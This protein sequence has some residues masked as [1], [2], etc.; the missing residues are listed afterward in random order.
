MQ[1]IDAKTGGETGRG[2]FWLCLALIMLVGALL[3]FW[4]LGALGLIVDEGYQ[5]L[6]VQ[7]ILDH[8]LPELDSGLLYTRSFIFLYLQALS[9][10]V[11][12]LNEFAM[13]FPAALFGVATIPLAYWFG[14]SL[15]GVRAG[16]LLAVL[17][18]LSAW[19]IEYARYA[20]FYT[21]FQG[22]YMIGLV[23]WFR[24]FIQMKVGWRWAFAGVF[25]L[26]IITQPLGVML[27]MS[28]VYLLPL[29]GYTAARKWVYFFLAGAC[30]AFW[31]LFNKAYWTVTDMLSTAV[32]ESEGQ[33]AVPV[34]TE[35]ASTAVGRLIEKVLAMVPAVKLPGLRFVKVVTEHDAWVLVAGAVVL[36]LVSVLIVWLSTRSRWA[37]REAGQPRPTWKWLPGVVLLVAIAWTGLVHMAAL[38]MVLAVA[39]LAFYVRS[40]KQLLRPEVVASALSCWAGM[41][42]WVVWFKLSPHAS[43]TEGLREMLSFPALWSYWFQWMLPGWPLMLG[44]M[45]VG[46]VVLARR[47]VTEDDTMNPYWFILAATLVPMVVTAQLE[48]KFSESRYFFHLYPLMLLWI[49]VLVVA[50][51]DVVKA[52]LPAMGGRWQM[53]ALTAVLG[54]ALL[55]LS[56]DADP[57]KAWAVTSREY[58]KHKDPV[59]SVLN[60]R[61]HANFHQDLKTASEAVRP[62]IGE[63]D[64][65]I[66]VGPPHQATVYR[67]YL[68]RVDY[69]ATSLDPY[70]SL[71]TDAQGRLVDLVT[72]GVMVS[73]AAGLQKVRDEADGQVWLFSD[74]P[75]VADDCWYLSDAEPA[76]KELV[77]QWMEEPYKTAEDYRTTVNRLP[78]GQMT[79]GG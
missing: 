57:C 47:S 17:F 58:G 62:E 27:G 52:K 46:F 24:G 6:A 48:W 78:G 25:L 11:F 4:R 9:N 3:R 44:M 8:G 70:L 31:V 21:L 56:Q 32:V 14:R 53:A 54:V 10:A 72:G 74:W 60:F 36:A 23:A 13:R 77:I 1:S 68:G 15:I 12:G 30:G 2:V 35:P 50:V 63:N 16:W 19:E 42:A 55:L 18:A 43:L 71:A 28:F 65:V 67:H 20:R 5:A 76:L 34:A 38:A 79:D 49:V 41:F 75:L 45:A 66:V 39:Y 40:W 7:G 73:T 61:W 37:A 64:V 69:I 22:L 29:R 59:R 26:A 51:G 33:N